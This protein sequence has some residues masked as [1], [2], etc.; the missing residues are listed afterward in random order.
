MT[1]PQPSRLCELTEMEDILA[2]QTIRLEKEI[3]KIKDGGKGR[4]GQIFKIA[5]L[6]QGPKKPGPEAHSVK[7]PE[8]GELVVSTK[9]IQNVFLKHC[10]EVLK[11]NSI[12]RGYQEEAEMKEKLN[13][14][15][16]KE[17]TGKFEATKE[18]FE[19]VIENFQKNNK[20]NYDFLVKGG[21]KFQHSM[22]L[23]VKRMISEERFSKSF[24]DTTLYNIYKGKGR[25]E[26]LESMR[27]IHLKSYL[28]RTLEAVVVDGMKEEILKGSSCYQIGG[29]PGHR[30]Q[31]HLFTVKSI[32][33]KNTEDGKV[34][35]G[36][37]HDIS[38]FFDKEVLSDVL[39][40]LT[41]MQ[42]D[43]KCV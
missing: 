6:V 35:I 11:S 37:V 34:L 33:A 17:S 4:C 36:G 43:P 8:T 7:D 5:Q 38:K 26:D 29:Q 10:K 27:F 40:T 13:E 20:R 30:S 1:V 39:Q 24:G 15:G 9:A 41:D 18:G 31:E 42:I 16:M 14:I 22:F 2:R 3:K 23:L 12:E 21:G 32:I 19:R 25:K 28:P